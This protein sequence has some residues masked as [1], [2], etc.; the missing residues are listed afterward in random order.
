MFKW[1]TI[2]RKNGDVTVTFSAKDYTVTDEEL[3]KFIQQFEKEDNTNA[4]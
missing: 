4:Q 1:I 2:I 3:T